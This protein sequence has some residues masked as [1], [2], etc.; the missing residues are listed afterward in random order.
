MLFALIALAL[1]A[2]HNIH[3]EDRYLDFSYS[4]PASMAGGPRFKAHLQKLETKEHRRRLAYAQQDQ[5]ESGPDFRQHSFKGIWKSQ[6]TSSR[7]LSETFSY[8]VL[9]GGAH[10]NSGSLALIWDRSSN[11]PVKFANLFSASAIPTNLKHHYCLALIAARDRRRDG[12]SPAGDWPNNCPK[13]DELTWSLIDR[14]HNGRFD[15]IKIEADPYVAGSY[16]EGAYV[17]TLPVSSSLMSAL[18]RSMQRD[19]EIQRQ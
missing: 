14:D 4:W 7:L 12:P 18:D 19:F 8:A 2:P 11:T 1:A 16:A 6:G 9:S 5:Q 10:G 17:I 3:R 13:D 15:R